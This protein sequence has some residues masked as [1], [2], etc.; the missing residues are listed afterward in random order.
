[1]AL[2][3]NPEVLVSVE[4]SGERALAL[5]TLIAQRGLGDRAH[6]HHGVDQADGP[7]LAG[8]VDDHLAGRPLDLVVDDASHLVGPT[9]A[10]FNV[11]FRGCARAGPTSSRTG[12]GRTSATARTGPRTHR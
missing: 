1:M 6:V 4:L 2:A 11:L 12:Q 10:S 3:A 9:R 8:L 7:A 5:D